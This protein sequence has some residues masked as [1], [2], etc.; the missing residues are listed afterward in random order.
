L[1]AEIEDPAENRISTGLHFTKKNAKKRLRGGDNTVELG[2]WAQRLDEA[3]QTA[4]ES[5]LR[6]GI[7]DLARSYLKIAHTIDSLIVPF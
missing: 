3:L 5:S 4:D 1:V 2:S 7:G 6:P